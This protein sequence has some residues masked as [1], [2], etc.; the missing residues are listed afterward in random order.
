MEITPEIRE[1]L[2]ETKETLSGYHRRHFMAQVVET[3][4]DG[5][6]MRAE[7]ELGWNRVTLGKALDE[8]RGGYCR[9]DQYPQRGRNRAEAHLPTLLDDMRELAER[10]SQTDP[11]FR[12]TRQYTR[13]TAVALRQQLIDEKGYTDEE[14]PTVQ[15]IRTKLNELGYKLKRVKKV[16]L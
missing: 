11:T 2:N 13:L 6:P 4:L 3:M 1:M 14:L 5:S 9:I 8:F 16:V 12:T 10:H 15:T 7:K